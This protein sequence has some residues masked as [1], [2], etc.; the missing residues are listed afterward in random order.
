MQ[1]KLELAKQ[2]AETAR[3]KRLL[4]VAQRDPAEE[5]EPELVVNNK[6]LFGPFR[7]W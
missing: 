5:P 4:L 3:E 1:L 6:A 2:E 7:V